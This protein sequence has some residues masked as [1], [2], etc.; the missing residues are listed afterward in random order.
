MTLILCLD[1]QGGMMFGTKRQSKDSALIRRLLSKTQGKRLVVSPYT[2]ALFAEKEELIVAEEPASL[3]GKNDFF[4][5]ENTA[6]PTEGIDTL[7]IYR[8]NRRYPATRFFKIP[9]DGYVLKERVDFPGSSH[10]LI[11]EERWERI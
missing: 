3:C 7:L 4:F 11:T 8:W 1:G 2:A 5:A 6:L 10:E 9:T